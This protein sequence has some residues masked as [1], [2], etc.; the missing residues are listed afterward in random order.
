MRS[1]KWLHGR[2]LPSA[3]ERVHSESYLKCESF[4]DVRL[5]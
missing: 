2:G 3:K 1:E 4:V 5:L